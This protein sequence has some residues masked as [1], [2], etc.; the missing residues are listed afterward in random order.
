MP[1]PS[2]DS[3]TMQRGQMRNLLLKYYDTL[4]AV[5]DRLVDTTAPDTS[6][7]GFNPG[8]RLP[9]L[10]ARLHDFFTCAE[11]AWWDVGI[12]SGRNLFILDLMRNKETG[13]TKSFASLVIVARAVAY[14]RETRQPIVIICPTS[15]NKGIALRDAVE[16]AI[17]YGLVGPE[18]LSIATILPERSAGKLRSSALS[19]DSELAQLNPVMV[20]DGPKADLVKTIAKTFID[21]EGAAFGKMRGAR[22]WYSLDIRNYKIAD[23]TR[24]MFEQDVSPT[25]SNRKRIHAHS[26]SSAYGLLGYNLGRDMIEEANH[27]SADSRPG[28]LLV[29][30]LA[31]PDMVLNLLN[32]SFDKTNLP[33]YVHNPHSGFHE[34]AASP[35]FPQK[36]W[37][38]AEILDRTFYT[39]CPSTSPEMNALIAAYGGTGIVVSLAECL[40]RYGQLRQR[41]I[42][43]D[44]NLPNDP[45]ELREWS[46]CMA[47]TGVVNAV[48]RGL[49]PADRD[50]VLHA[51]GAYSADQYAPIDA[52]ALH[53]VSDDRSFSHA[54]WSSVTLARRAV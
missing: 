40:D 43:T 41:L 18:E 21:A 37:D 49:V 30:H 29:Q 52:Q 31:T 44:I 20:F 45:R 14:I 12:L 16:R 19:S 51:S 5:I 17:R 15:G 48:E 38:V 6:E 34:Q 4:P 9:A 2:P 24:A 23:A 25:A 28:F 35:H 26:V 32:G 39:Q 11:V 7:T 10:D 53:R 46:L 42:K 36:T 54:M 3:E 8:F 50:I 33:P 22:L 27:S 1:Y 47:F 13:T